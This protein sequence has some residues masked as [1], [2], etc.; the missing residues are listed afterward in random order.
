MRL[1]WARKLSQKL[2]R[3]RRCAFKGEWAGR[4]RGVLRLQLDWPCVQ[5]SACADAQQEPRAVYRTCAAAAVGR[6]PYSIVANDFVSWRYL[7]S[8][9]PTNERT[10]PTKNT[11]WGRSRRCA[12]YKPLQ[13]LHPS[14]QR[15]PHVA[16]FE[17]RSGVAVACLGHA[18][19][20]GD[21]I[22]Q[23]TPRVRV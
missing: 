5:S 12:E 23:H 3:R 16:S 17:S 4:Q 6:L 11:W 22:A 21:R 20:S 8:I 18:R 14:H 2:S 10:A 19:R 1:H 15:A 13:P 7:S 9:A